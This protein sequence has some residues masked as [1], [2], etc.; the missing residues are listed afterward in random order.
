MRP[1]VLPGGAGSP[2]DGLLLV[3]R[4][5]C[6]QLSVKPDSADIEKGHWATL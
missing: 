5:Q 1:Q 4:L 2:L 6:L 3:E